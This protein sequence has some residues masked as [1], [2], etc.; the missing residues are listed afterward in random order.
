MRNLKTHKRDPGQCKNI[1]H[2]FY[3]CNSKTGANC[4]PIIGIKSSENENIVCQ[5]GINFRI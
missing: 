1:V 3:V 5:P 4:D 2:S